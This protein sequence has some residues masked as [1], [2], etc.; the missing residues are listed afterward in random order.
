MPV[1]L[2]FRDGSHTSA[3]WKIVCRNKLVL[4]MMTQMVHKLLNNHS[5]FLFVFVAVRSVD[6][7]KQYQK[8]LTCWIWLQDKKYQEN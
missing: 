8:N 3:L 7:F 2:Q 1:R 6:G 5:F 4:I